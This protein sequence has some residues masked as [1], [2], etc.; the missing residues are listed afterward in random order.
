MTKERNIKRY[1]KKRLEKMI[2]EGQDQ[3]DFARLD[4]MTEAKIDTSDIP[5]LGEEFWK[6]A[7]LVWPESKSRITLRVDSDV[8]GWLKQQGK[9]YQTRINAILRAY[10][11]SHKNTS[12]KPQHG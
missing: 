6:N 9:G 4:A 3:T 8:L 1:T 10:M 7:K 12:R 5:P 11:L 2:A